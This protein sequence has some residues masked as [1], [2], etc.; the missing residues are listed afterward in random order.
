MSRVRT[1][2]IRLA[3]ELRPGDRALLLYPQGLEFLCAFLACLAAGVIAVP[4]YPPRGRRNSNQLNGVFVDCSPAAILT[5][6]SL[7]S[8]VPAQLHATLVLMTDEWPTI[9]APQWTRDHLK[10][11]SVAYLQYTSGST[12]APNGVMITHQALIANIEQSATAL[13]SWNNE[14]VMVSWLPMFHDMGLVGCLLAPLYLGGTAVLM[15]PETFLRKPVRWL[16]AITSERATLSSCPNFGFDLCVSSVSDEERQ[17]LDLSSLRAVVNGAEPVR[18][19]TIDRFVEKFR[20]CGFSPEK[21]F[22]SFGLAEATLFVSGGPYGRAPKRVPVDRRASGPV[23]RPIREAWGSAVEERPSE[24]PAR[25]GKAGGTPTPQNGA[26]G[27]PTP[28]GAERWV[29][30]CGVP[31]VGARVVAVDRETKTVCAEGKTGEIWV[32]SPSNGAGYW[33]KPELSEQTFRNFLANGEGPFL[34]TGD[35]GFLLEGEVYVT[36]RSKDLIIIRGRNIY[37]QDVE[38]VVERALPLAGPNACA[39]I[40]INDFEGEQLGIV[41][42][43]N[44]DLLRIARSAEIDLAAAAE[45]KQHVGHV[46]QAVADEFQT[47]VQ[48]VAVVRPGGFPRTSSGKVQRHRCR[49][50][51]TK[52]NEAVVYR[53]QPPAVTPVMD[54]PKERAATPESA[55]VPESVAKVDALIGWLRDYAGRKINSRLID[56]RRCVPPHV[57]LDFGSQGLFGL[58][59]P[60]SL[61]GLGL[62]T[63]DGLRVMEQLAAIDTTLALMVGIHNGLGL[64]P[65]VNFGSDALR[66]ERVPA[67]ASGRQLAAFALTEPGAGSNPLAMQATAH[68]V[69]GG[70]RLCAEKQWIGLGSWAGCL[71]AF[72]RGLDAQG[73][74]AGIVALAV[75]EDS[76]G[77][78]HGAES[79]TM[80]VRGIVQNTVYFDDVFVPDV[81]ALGQPGQG[82][83]VAHDAMMH[84]RLGLA[85]ISVGGM[86]RCAQLMLRYAERRSISTGRLLDNPVTLGRLEE[87]CA[88]IDALQALT[89]LVARSIDAG[90]PPPPEVFIACKTVGPELCWQAADHLVQFLG[91]RGYVETNIAPQLLR[92]A[93]LLRIFEGPTETLEVFLGASVMQHGNRLQNFLVQEWGVRSAAT[94]LASAIGELDRRA[95]GPH[96][97]AERQRLHYRLGGLAGAA[98][99]WAAAEQQQARAAFD[100]AACRWAE[101]RFAALLEAA[102]ADVRRTTHCTPEYLRNRIQ[103]YENWI[104]DVE[105]QLPGEEHRLD[106]YLRRN[107]PESAIPQFTP[108]SVTADHTSLP[109][110]VTVTPFRHAGGDDG[111]RQKLGETLL[112]WLRRHVDSTI[113][114]IDDNQE[115]TTFGIDSVDASSIA[116]EIQTAVGARITPDLLYEFPT[117]ARL[118]EYLAKAAPLIEYRNRDAAI[119]PRGDARSVRLSHVANAASDGREGKSHANGKARK[120]DLLEFRARNRAA[121]NLKR[122]G[123]YFYDAA[124]EAIDGPYVKIGTKKMLMLASFAYT[125]LVGNEEVNAAA[126]QAIEQFGSGCHGARLIAGTTSVH[127]EL[128][129]RLA[130]FMRADDALLFSS[131]YS[132]NVATIPAVVGTGDWILADEYNHASLVDGCKLSGANFQVFSHNDV[133]GLEKLLRQARGGRRLVAV[134]GVYSMEGDVAPLPEI[135]DLCRRYDALLMVDEA[136]SL[137]VLGKTGR[138]VQEHFNLPADAIDLK[139]GNTSKS[140]ASLG[141]FIAGKQVIVDYLRHHARGYVF[142]TSLGP[143]Q[144]AAALKALEVLEREPERVARLQHNALR[145][146]GG[147]REIGFRLAETQ[148]A[149]VPLLCQTDEKAFEMTARCREAGLFVVPIVYPAVPMN[150]PRLRLTVMANHTDDEIDQALAILIGSGRK[151][152][153][154]R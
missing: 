149:I 105:Q 67:L 117:I 27:T 21:M 144:V 150:A 19:E 115:L 113:S 3:E 39:A 73:L 75:R 77:V 32:R 87:L 131:G 118:A 60:E 43:A 99:V 18:A 120:D 127:R 114:S 17:R 52:G 33:G 136:H 35:L 125:G 122:H 54:R 119:A 70:W 92:D 154:C 153:L 66:N 26:G 85:A 65:L 123:R 30:S 51:L 84:C 11:G 55:A 95:T 48:A 98:I 56:E 147:L 76:P 12:S 83:E 93:R 28:Q 14:V 142:S 143:P 107:P 49:E 124:Y 13:D 34:N 68:R 46:R 50:L 4:S 104:G 146:A 24:T 139:M 134:D 78:R 130:R 41:V 82:M 152:G 133:E 59:V 37:P 128:E 53:W 42:E 61:G 137:G 135:V 89:G 22:P 62:S 100:A 94:A 126:E 101:E 58:Q 112:D 103:Q 5:L 72:A 88:A 10:S 20:A 102:R 129:Q 91:G 25:E 148:S 8:M 36:G 96:P 109:R 40:A 9:S 86:R 7:R 81:A 151:L 111:L 38:R 138:G 71:T 63:F 145:L 64:R 79:L 106:A 140:L 31:A 57:V 141:G 90:Q 23:S 80:G 45:L 29:V 110:P 108:A 6:A 121:D 132:A 116:I 74:P 2:A 1:I 47:A 16:E 44:L 97:P 69:E 15:S